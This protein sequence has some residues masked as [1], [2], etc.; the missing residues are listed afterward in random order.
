MQH[1]EEVKAGVSVILQNVFG[2]VEAAGGIDGVCFRERAANVF[3]CSVGHL[4]QSL[5]VCLCAAGMPN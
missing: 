4:L 2:S 3:L 1:L 5:S